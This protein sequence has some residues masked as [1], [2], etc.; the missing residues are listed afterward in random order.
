MEPIDYSKPP[1]A[2]MDYSQL[3]LPFVLDSCIAKRFIGRAG[4]FF[5]LITERCRAKY[6]WYVKEKNIV[7][8]WARNAKI[9]A[10]VKKQLL[11]HLSKVKA[12][13]SSETTTSE[14]TQENESTA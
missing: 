10:K 1:F 5:I 13:L 7:E 9:I 11:K 8:I 3:E 2:N 14:P 12:Q 4:H 6:I